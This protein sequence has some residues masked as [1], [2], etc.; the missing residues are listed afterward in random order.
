M[1]LLSKTHIN[2]F[3]TFKNPAPVQQYSPANSPAIP[4]L[5]RPDRS[6]LRVLYILM[7]KNS[8]K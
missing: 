6:I 3:I 7:N 4:L 5:L 2:L 8:E 1:G